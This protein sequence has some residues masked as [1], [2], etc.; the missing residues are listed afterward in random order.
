MK[1][2]ILFLSLLFS[3]CIRQLSAQIPAQEKYWAVSDS[4]Q[5][6]FNTSGLPYI[7]TSP[8]RSHYRAGATYLDS[9][10]GFYCFTNGKNFFDSTNQIMSGSYPINV[11]GGFRSY[12]IPSYFNLD[13]IYNFCFGESIYNS[14]TLNTIDK[15]QNNGLGDIVASYA[16]EDEFDLGQWQIT[17]DTINRGIRMVRHGDGKQMWILNH[18]LTAPPTLGPF[19]NGTSQAWVRWLVNNDSVSGP[20]FQDIGMYYGE[21]LAFNP[22]VFSESGAKLALASYTNKIELFDFDRCTGLLSNPVVIDSGF[23]LDISVPSYNY[24]DS[25]YISCAFSASGYYLYVNSFDT[26]WQYDMLASNIADSRMVIWYDTNDVYGL[27]L[28]TMELGPDGR[29]YVGTSKRQNFNGQIVSYTR[30]QYNTWMGVIDKPDLE[31]ISCDFKRYALY[32]DGHISNGTTP[33]RY[34][35]QLGVWVGSPCDPNVTG[36]DQEND[37]KTKLKI[38]PNPASDKLNITWPVQGGYTWAL[39][40]IAGVTLSSGASSSTSSVSISTS[41]LP[42]GMYFLE[43]HSAKEHKVEKVLIVR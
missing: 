25:G 36:V 6:E 5:F 21:D 33:V 22:I 18:L 20:Y 13:Y 9:I 30:N 38:F 19:Q 23:E 40:T 39:K 37:L 34:N 31:G 35:T 15:T 10:T 17:G 11:S 7:T 26:L 29:I 3:F 27:I 24:V 2:T 41:T 8:L 32:L 16:Y 4:M 28:G 42:V 14:F 12:F 1:T 43:I